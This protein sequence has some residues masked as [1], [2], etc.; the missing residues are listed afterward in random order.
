MNL[1]TGVLHIPK[2]KGGEVRAFDLPLPTLL[3][4]LFRARWV[5]HEKLFA[6]DK[7]RRPGCSPRQTR[8]LVTLWKC[9]PGAWVSARTTCAG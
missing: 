9:A 4:D 8:P 3:V 2:P 1:D 7:K 6:E 5:Q